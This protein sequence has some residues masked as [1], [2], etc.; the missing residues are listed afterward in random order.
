MKKHFKVLGIIVMAAM[1]GFFFAACSGGGG[2]NG[3]GIG[4]VD[5]RLVNAANEAW[6]DEYGEGSRDGFVLKAD[7][8]YLA[9]FVS[10]NSWHSRNSN[11]RG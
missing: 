6:L 4:S 10:A 7:G 5:S 9:L 1:I 8:T 3:G 2:V 11:I